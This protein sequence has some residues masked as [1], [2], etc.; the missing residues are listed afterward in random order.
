MA[1]LNTRPDYSEIMVKLGKNAEN[2]TIEHLFKKLPDFEVV[3]EC[4][5]NTGN[6]GTF[7]A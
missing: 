3:K 5:L 4:G 1:P 2:S 6:D 7:S